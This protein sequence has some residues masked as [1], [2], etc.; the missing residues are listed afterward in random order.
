MN[1]DVKTETKKILGDD[2]Y[3]SN[4]TYDPACYYF[5]Y[6][7]ELK[8]YGL[9]HFVRETLQKKVQGREVRFATIIPDV[10]SQYYYDNVIVINPRSMG[11]S[12]ADNLSGTQP[13]KT[14][15]RLTSSEFMTAISESATI[16]LLIAHILENQRQ[17]FLSMF[18]SIE[19]MTLDEIDGVSILGPNKAIAKKYNSKLVQFTELAGQVPMVEGEICHGL[20]TLLQRTDALRASWSEGIFVSAAYS[21]AGVNSAVTRTR[22]DVLNRFSDTD[23]EYVITRYYPHDLDPTVLAV[24]ANADEVYIAGIADQKIIDGNKFVGSAFPS[25]INKEQ[26]ALLNKHTIAAG[27]LLG[28][29]GYR[30]IF[31]CDFI[32]DH[33]GRIWFLEINARKQGTTFE[34]CCTLEQNLPQD[35]PSLPELECHAVLHSCFPPETVVMEEN[36]CGLHWQTYNHKLSTTVLTTGFIPQNTGER[37]SF[38]KVAKKELQ[39]DFVV[40]EHLGAPLRIMPGAF[41]AR[42][43]SIA[44]SKEDVDAGLRQGI[45][46]INQTFQKV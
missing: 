20:A 12:T 45:G 19:E 4:F 21:A 13:L 26:A 1:K 36:V 7:G 37:E 30:G 38:A 28:R 17:L 3:Y 46:W 8:A 5:L 33:Q 9:N 40:L 32:I 22:E 41:L 23:G 16:R 29:A 31:G 14:S 15:C 43:V 34:F 6:I 10:C 39:K 35:A 42:V 24:V 2:L 27:R 18:E 44:R 25:Q 11:K